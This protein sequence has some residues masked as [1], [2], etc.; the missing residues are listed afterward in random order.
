MSNFIGF[1]RLIVYNGKAQYLDG[2]KEEI[3][4]KLN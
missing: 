1:I 2:L 4:K 3:E